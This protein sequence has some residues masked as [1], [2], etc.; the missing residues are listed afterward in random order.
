[1]K[2]IILLI[3]SHSLV[4]IFGVALGIYLLP[5]LTAPDAPS[6]EMMQSAQSDASYQGEFQ[7][8]L[9]GSDFFH[10]GE[11]TLF[12]GKSVISLQGELA[13]GPDYKL[14]LSSEFVEDEAEFNLHRKD[15]VRVG[16]IRTFS[17]FAVQVPQH[18]DPSGYRVAVVWCESFGEFITAARY[19]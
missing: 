13:P 2:K 15:M 12:V 9:K 16:D 1:M 14:Y 17:N 6:V 8:D 11:G 4:G 19:Q 3:V 5:I 7:R 10:W 18:I